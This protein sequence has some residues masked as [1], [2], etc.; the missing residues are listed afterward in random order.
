MK[1]RL[2]PA[3]VAALLLP[4]LATAAVNAGD[5]PTLRFTE[6]TSKKPVDLS[7]FKGKIVVV[8][9]WATWCGPCMHEAPHMVQV[10][11]DFAAKGLQFVGVSLDSDPSALTPV[12]KAKGFTWPMSYE[13]A[14][15]SGKTPK[16]WGV[17]SIPQTF[18]IGP[19]GT[20][21]WRGHPAELDEPLAKAFK[22]HPPQLVDP[23][24]LASANATI[25]AAEQAVD[26]D[27]A[28][29]AKLLATVPAAARSDADANAKV[30]AV[31]D[32]L[33][34]YGQSKL[35]AAQQQVD[36]KQFGPA[37]RTLKD[38]TTALA[39][40]PAAATAK[41]KLAELMKDPAVRT[42][43]IADKRTAAAD[44]ALASAAKLKSAGRDELAYPK[45]KSVAASYAGTPAGTEAADVA[46]AYEADAAF[47]AKVKGHADGR[48]AAATLAMA[49]TYRA[50]GNATSAKAKYQEVV[51]QFPGT[52][53]AKT[54]QAA[55]D[56]MGTN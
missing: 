53:Q 55:L 50:A 6:F 2:I 41:Q 49:D 28:K 24:T 38:L 33:T 21:L 1:T 42:A 19:D 30:T 32:K 15:W 25:A 45:Y 22:D 47:M 29:A 16:E 20:V 34:A 46:R 4:R 13:G 31:T 27:P 18:I 36:A 14:G 9:F 23:K 51:K 39:G 37:A 8:D 44:E 52:P 17:D 7:A 10:N 56:G 12:I 35:D 43:M 40:Q 5:K 26:A 54:A 11:R 3:L 48:R